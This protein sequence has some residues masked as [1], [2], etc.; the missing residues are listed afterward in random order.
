VKG[1]TQFGEVT[2]FGS[3]GFTQMILRD[4]ERYWQGRVT[5]KALIDDL[6]NGHMHPALGVPVVSSAERLRDYADLPV[7]L[8]PGSGALRA[9]VATRL[10]G[11]N[12]VL[13]TASCPGQDH[14]DPS[15]EYG[16]GCIC[17]PFTRLGANVVIGAGSHVFGATVA[18]DC[19]IGAFS[20]VGVDASVLGHVIIGDN[21]TIGPGAVIA[22]G[23]RERPR[24]IGDGAIIGVG[25]V[26]LRD[27][28][29]GAHVIGNP[30]MPAR[31]W[32]KL[33]RLLE[34][35]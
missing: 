20:N 29:P 21:V 26:V 14:V 34:G 5:V 2:V 18:H 11:E 8:T 6:E 7:L 22:N 27:V 13:A 17:A 30:A 28:P 16:A 1:T 32:A 12:S 4:M 9:E 35:D 31:Q 15:V 25:A 23:T 24:R 19:Q 10:A 3:R 33:T